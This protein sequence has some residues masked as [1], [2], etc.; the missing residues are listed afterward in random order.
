MLALS[1][2]PSHVPRLFQ[3][4]FGEFSWPLI[5]CEVVNDGSQRP[6]VSGITF[7]R[8]SSLATLCYLLCEFRE[9]L[10]FLPSLTFSPFLL[11]PE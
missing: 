3:A 9:R 10:G 6:K 1:E 4:Q 11:G 8:L 5:F 2:L 7:Y